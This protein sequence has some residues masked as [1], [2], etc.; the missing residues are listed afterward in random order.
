MGGGNLMGII[1]LVLLAGTVFA[2]V[3]PGPGGGGGGGSA[4]TRGFYASVPSCTSTNNGA[5][6]STTDIGGGYDGQ[7]NG[8]SW[9]W[10]FKGFPITPPPV[11]GS[12]TW[13]NQGSS[14]YTTTTGRA[15]LSGLFNSS[16]NLR[17]LSFSSPATPYSY[18]MRFSVDQGIFANSYLYFLGFVDSSTGNMKDIEILVDATTSGSRLSYVRTGTWAGTNYW[19]AS[20]TETNYGLVPVNEDFILKIA[21]DGTNTIFKISNSDGAIYTT[22]LSQTRTTFTANPNTVVFGCLAAASA[23]NCNMTVSDLTQGTN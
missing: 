13:V 1:L 12:L 19:T 2:Q 4:S 11:I 17:G 5:F 9:Q 20:P 16:V 10:Y 14:T 7:C 3:T 15:V 6:Y 23:G 22:V 8:S 18:T 21:D